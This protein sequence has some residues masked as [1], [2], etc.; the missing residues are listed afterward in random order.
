[1]LTLYA[2]RIAS[3]FIIFFINKLF[4]VNFI[5]SI[6]VTTTN[7]RY[8]YEGY[9]LLYFFLLI[10]LDIYSQS[11]NSSIFSINDIPIFFDSFFNKCV[12]I[13]GDKY[14]ECLTSQIYLTLNNI[15]LT[16]N[17]KSTLVI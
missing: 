7:H 13:L 12:M 9:K 8:Q 6:L 17:I 16:L 15:D 5:L 4:L 14:K 1:M 3:V 2:S 10:F 11:S